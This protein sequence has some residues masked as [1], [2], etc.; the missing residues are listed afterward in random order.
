MFRDP[1]WWPAVSLAT[2]GTHVTESLADWAMIEGRWNHP[3]IVMWV[4]FN[5]GWGQYDTPRFCQW[6][7][8]LD[9][10]RLVNNASGWTDRKA[11]DVDVTGLSG[12]LRVEATW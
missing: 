9:P 5:E 12:A 6:I 3:C 11:G 7:K 8:Q 10:S 2:T 4:P 1:A